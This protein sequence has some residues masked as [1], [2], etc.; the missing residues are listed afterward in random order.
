MAAQLWLGEDRHLSLPVQFDEMGLPI[1]SG[2]L[3]MLFAASGDLRPVCNSEEGRQ[4]AH[5]EGSAVRCR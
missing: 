3:F 2:L 5:R 1:K 4:S